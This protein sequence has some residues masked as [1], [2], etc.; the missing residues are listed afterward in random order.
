MTTNQN[1]IRLI[2]AVSPI[3]IVSG[4]NEQ[5]SEAAKKLAKIAKKY[6][7]YQSSELAKIGKDTYEMNLAFTNLDMY[8]HYR[9]DAKFEGVL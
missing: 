5:A 4:S 7:G 3:I 6:G 1:K 9:A 8:E 2:A